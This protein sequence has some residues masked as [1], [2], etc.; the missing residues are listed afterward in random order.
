M[1]STYT[2]SQIAEQLG[3][4]INTL[5]RIEE[6]LNLNIKRDSKNARQY[7]EK[8]LEL[9][10]KVKDLRDQAIPY[11]FIKATLA[12]EIEEDRNYCEETELDTDDTL[13]SKSEEEAAASLAALEESIEID[14]KIPEESG[15]SSQLNV[16]TAII[17]QLNIEIIRSYAKELIKEGIREALAQELT[18]INVHLNK[19]DIDHEEINKKVDE[20]LE[21]QEK[22]FAA[23]DAKLTN[24]RIAHSQTAKKKGFFQ[25][26]LYK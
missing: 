21:L 7:T 4:S 24:W 23:L 26:L 9:L 10:K 1:Q 14:A 20:Q 3:M 19:I 11:E 25:R 6:E 15:I 8:N 16:D 13:N 12:E 5:R 2:I 17:K 18:N 22:H